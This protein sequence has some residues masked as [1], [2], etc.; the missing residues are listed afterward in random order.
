MRGVVMQVEGSKA[1]L[2]VQGGEFRQVKNKGY[3]VG[4]KVNIKRRSMAKIGTLAA[5]LAV[6][7][8][9]GGAS[10]F[11]PA[12]YVSVDINPSFLMTLNIYDKVISVEPL[13]TEAEDMLK[14]TDVFGKNINDTVSELIDKSEKNGYISNET[15]EVIMSV[16]PRI[17]TPKIEDKN[18]AD[19]VNLVVSEADKNTLD[20]AKEMGVSIAKAKAIEEYTEEFGGTV[21]TNADKLGGK[22]VKQIRNEIAEKKESSAAPAPVQTQKPNSQPVNNQ[23][24]SHAAEKVQPNSAKA[25]SSV[26]TPEP[27]KQ[28][29][30]QAFAQTPEVINQ[31]V[32]EEK[33]KPAEVQPQIEEKPEPVIINPVE[34]MQPAETP[35][36]MREDTEVERDIPVRQPERKIAEPENEEAEPE[37]MEE[38]EA[39]EPVRS[40]SATGGSGKHTET[41]KPDEIKEPERPEEPEQDRGDDD[42]EKDRNE[43]DREDDHYDDDYEDEHDDHKDDHESDRDDIKSDDRE[44]DRDKENDDSRGDGAVKENNT[45]PERNNEPP[46]RESAPAGDRGGENAPPSGG[47]NGGGAP[48]DGGDRR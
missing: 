45:Q 19:K 26:T 39:P 16:V 46:Q 17:R 31:P 29:T 33:P 23:Q 3:S 5:A 34:N 25:Y 27:M 42:R 21:R 24:L 38:H 18:K 32:F 48:P 47:D 6:F 1:V 37:K 35:S 8:I 13:N 15:G 10:Y 22:N 4:D 44:N 14:T 41:K 9:G 36:L 11:M 43:G 12:S 28:S 7:I 2:L 20:E 40:N 30:V